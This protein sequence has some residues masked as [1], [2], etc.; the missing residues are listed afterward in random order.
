MHEKDA[1]SIIISEIG[2][3]IGLFAA[4]TLKISAAAHKS[5][6]LRVYGV[7]WGFL[8]YIDIMRVTFF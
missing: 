8:C 6:V 5:T 4:A 2:L 3:Y 7:V 1:F